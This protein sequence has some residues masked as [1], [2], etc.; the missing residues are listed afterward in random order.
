MPCV[1]EQRGGQTEAIHPFSA[2]AVR[3]GRVT[4]ALGDMADTSFRSGAKPFQLAC[5]LDAMG[6]PGLPERWLAIGA[7]SHSAE[8][9]HLELVRSVLAGFELGADDLQCGTHPP[10]NADAAFALAREG[11]EFGPIHNNCSGKHAFMLAACQA[12]GWPLDYRP[13][14]H[15]L[16]RLIVHKLRSWCR[17]TQPGLMIDGCGVPTFFLPLGAIAHA[18]SEMATAMRGDKDDL[19][20]RIGLAMARHPLLV[21]GTGRLEPAL[22][23]AATE[24]MAAKIGA[25]GL[26]C[27]A[28]PARGLGVA[29]KVASG[30]TDALAIAVPAAL[31][32]LA[33]GAIELPEDW[34]WATVRNWVGADVGVRRAVVGERC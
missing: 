13:Y 14:D 30:S 34:P 22:V 32:R 6:S 33:P 12:Q 29:V 21:A 15:P 5:S 11:V 7:S 4:A 20:G 19:L 2:L 31:E 18:W 28:L 16:Q 27:V 26:F 10:A 17:D 24:P 8:P 23:A 9:S 3:D 25:M 1:L